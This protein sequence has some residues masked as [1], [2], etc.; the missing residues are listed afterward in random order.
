MTAG[1]EKLKCSKCNEVTHHSV[2]TGHN[3]DKWYVRVCEVCK[4][5]THEGVFLPNDKKS[6]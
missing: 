4:T 6:E 2:L 5:L 1:F 3:G